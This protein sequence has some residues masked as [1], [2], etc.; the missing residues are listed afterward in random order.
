MLFA[1]LVHPQ[2]IMQARTQQFNTGRGG[3]LLLARLELPKILKKSKYKDKTQ[4]QNPK[5]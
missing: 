1:I 3:L 2:S 5:Y 4:S